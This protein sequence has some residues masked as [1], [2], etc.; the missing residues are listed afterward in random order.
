MYDI[1]DAAIIIVFASI[2][3]AILYMIKRSR[4][5]TFVVHQQYSSCRENFHGLPTIAYFSVLIM[6]Q[7]NFQ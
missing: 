3:K 7:E 2:G 6:K 4:G 5:N 1:I